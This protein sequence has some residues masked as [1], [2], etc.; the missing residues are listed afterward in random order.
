M[1]SLLTKQFFEFSFAFPSK[2]SFWK[3]KKLTVGH[4]CIIGVR[5]V[6]LMYL[7]HSM[8][9]T[10]IKGCKKGRRKDGKERLN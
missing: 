5:D 6:A 10:K 2:F 8:C 1:T 3:E 9:S 7:A 4:G